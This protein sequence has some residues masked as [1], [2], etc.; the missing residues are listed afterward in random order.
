MAMKALKVTPSKLKSKATE[1]NSKASE[2]KATTNEMF[3]IIKTLNGAVWSGEAANA[4]KNRFNELND[5][6]TKMYKMI[7]KYSDDLIAIA[8]EYIAAENANE[9]TGKAL[10]INVIS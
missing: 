1:F 8:N 2:V 3:A 5:D 9:A 7:K 4:Y 6:C 10:K